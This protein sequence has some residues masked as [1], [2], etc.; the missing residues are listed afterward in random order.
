VTPFADVEDLDVLEEAAV[1]GLVVEPATMVGQ[2]G[3]EQM[4]ERLSYS[5]VPTV[6]LAAHT[7]YHEISARVAAYVEEHFMSQSLQLADA[8]IGATA[9][10]HRLALLTADGRHYRVM[11]ALDIEKFRP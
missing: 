7:L 8:L 3:L 6:T 9:V 2:L 11:G 5:V 1:R 4:E 10:T